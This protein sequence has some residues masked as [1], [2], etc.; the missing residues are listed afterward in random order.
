[1]AKQK[2]LLK[3]L[4]PIPTLALDNIPQ[5]LTTDISILARS[6]TVEYEP[7][8]KKKM[9]VS[10]SETNATT[11]KRTTLEAP[12]QSTTISADPYGNLDGFLQLRDIWFN[13]EKAGEKLIVSYIEYRE[14]IE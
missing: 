4:D 11:L 5:R 6:V 2:Q 10:D 1:M 7:A 9:F 3:F 13:G 12:M 14:P 8:N